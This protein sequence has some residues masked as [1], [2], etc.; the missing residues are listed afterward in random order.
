MTELSI[1]AIMEIMKNDPTDE[2]V[3]E[4]LKSPAYLKRIEEL[5]VLDLGRAG[6]W[7]LA[8][9]INFVLNEHSGEEVF[10]ALAITLGYT[11]ACVDDKAR[12]SMTELVARS[13]SSAKS[14]FLMAKKDGK[15]DLNAF[16]PLQ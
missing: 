16:R 11:L 1:D 12:K 3:A 2:Q 15:L 6:V 7:D 5:G 13:V 9:E 8:R 10:A 4:I 14:S